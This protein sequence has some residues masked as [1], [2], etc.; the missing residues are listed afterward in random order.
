M[1]RNLV[2][3]SNWAERGTRM[4]TELSR[5][6]THSRPGAAYHLCVV[7][8]VDVKWP[9]PQMEDWH[10]FLENELHR[11]CA[12]SPFMPEA[13]HVILRLNTGMNIGAWDAGWRHHPDFENYLFLQDEVR[14]VQENWLSAYVDVGE[15]LCHT[16]HSLFLI[17]ESWNSKWDKA[18]PE[19]HRGALNTY[20][21]GHPPDERRVDYYLRCMSQWNINPGHSGGHL[22]SL[23]WFSNL[24]TLQKI[25]GFPVGNSYGEC[26]AA[27]IAVNRS[28]IEQG[29]ILKSIGDLPFQVFAH[30]EWSSNGASK[31]IN[32]P[33][34]L[35]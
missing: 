2:V 28:V 23:I 35:S 10:Q 16:G 14:L 34:K 21:P 32:E 19:L 25:G 1:S 6:L 13:V 18:W 3:I 17:G 12:Q 20:S 7:S 33:R 24:A 31:N 9:A 22:R 4:L 8:N 30:P 15:A 29:G 5:Q 26:I 11:A 27:E